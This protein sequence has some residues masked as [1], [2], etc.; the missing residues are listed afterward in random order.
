MLK[1]HR[2]PMG[3]SVVSTDVAVGAFADRPAMPLWILTIIICAAVWVLGTIAVAA[4]AVWL[5]KQPH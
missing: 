5:N 2:A 1:T 3:Q 4:G